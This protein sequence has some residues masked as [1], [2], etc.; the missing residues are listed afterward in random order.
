M[1]NLNL[2]LKATRQRAQSRLYESSCLA[3]RMII[4]NEEE[5]TNAINECETLDGLTSI[6]DEFENMIRNPNELIVQF[7]SLSP[8]LS[9][10]GKKSAFSDAAPTLHV[11]TDN[12]TDPDESMYEFL[13]L[14]DSEVVDLRNMKDAADTILDELSAANACPEENDAQEENGSCEDPHD[15]N[16]EINTEKDTITEMLMKSFIVPNNSVTKRKNKS[17][18][19]SEE[20]EASPSGDKKRGRPPLNPEDKKP[21][22]KKIK[23]KKNGDSTDCNDEILNT[24]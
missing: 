6:T 12:E 15:E 9:T 22:V 8:R 20:P 19:N 7:N 14:Y 21:K 23:A 3:H 10:M 18:R 2:L 13:S 1:N 17:P 16:E 4:I 11:I 5:L 24:N